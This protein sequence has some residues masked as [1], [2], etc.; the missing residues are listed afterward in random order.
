MA[1]EVAAI[2]KDTQ[3]LDYAIAT[4]PVD[5]QMPGISHARSSHFG[6]AHL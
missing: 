3:H 2:V 1:L 4:L 6:A 5:N